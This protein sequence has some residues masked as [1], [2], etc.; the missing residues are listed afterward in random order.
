MNWFLPADPGL[1]QHHQQDQEYQAGQ[2][3]PYSIAHMGAHS[4]A[5]LCVR[6]RGLGRHCVG[7]WR[8]KSSSGQWGPSWHLPFLGCPCVVTPPCSLPLSL[9]WAPQSSYCPATPLSF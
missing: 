2:A 6:G 1:R 3:Q 9:L 7:V 8:E 4:R 5:F